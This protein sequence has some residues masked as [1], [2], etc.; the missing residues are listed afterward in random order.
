MFE[1]KQKRMEC[2]ITKNMRMIFKRIQSNRFCATVWGPS[3]LDWKL[4]PL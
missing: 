1:T 3:W 2:Y 4:S